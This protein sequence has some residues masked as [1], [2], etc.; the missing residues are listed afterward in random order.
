M[1]FGLWS[2]VFGPWSLVLG[3]WSLVLGLW[4]LVLCALAWKGLAATADAVCVR[5]R[6]MYF[7]GMS[8]G[9]EALRRLWRSQPSGR[10]YSAPAAKP[11]GARARREGARKAARP[12]ARAVAGPRAAGVREWLRHL[13]MMKVQAWRWHFLHCEVGGMLPRGTSHAAR[14]PR[15][16]SPPARV[17]RYPSVQIIPVAIF[18]L[19]TPMRW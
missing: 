4:S 6:A 13:S 9:L 19:H 5:C 7:L 17:G 11:G 18:P 14:T 15:L 10:G 8:G 16:S 2:L 1:V 3:L 12:K